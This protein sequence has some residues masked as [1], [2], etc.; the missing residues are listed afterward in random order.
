MTYEYIVR[1]LGEANEPKTQENWINI[2]ARQRFTL[3]SVTVVGIFAY[4]Y[5][6]RL[7]KEE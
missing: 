3:I 1:Y 6:Q 7:I 5:F 2:F 4:G